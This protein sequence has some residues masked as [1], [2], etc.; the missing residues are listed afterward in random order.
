[1]PNV[2]QAKKAKKCD[3]VPSI[4]RWP[5]F[6][7]REVKGSI[8]WA[9]SKR[10]LQ[11]EYRRTFDGDAGKSSRSPRSGIDVHSVLPDVGMWHRRMAVDDE[12]A[13]VLRRAEKF[14]TNPHQ[15]VEVLLPDGNARAN[16]GMHEQEIAAAEAVA[17]AL[18]ENLV[19]T[20]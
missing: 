14:I 5:E 8:S 10:F 3:E 19:R 16:A 12:F 20:R 6:L 2:S 9:R 4:C 7:Q 1:M 18:Q 15:V 17:E 11:N 13:M